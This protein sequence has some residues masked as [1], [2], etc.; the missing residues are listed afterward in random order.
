MLKIRALLFVHLTFLGKILL[1]HFIMIKIYLMNL[2][3]LNLKVE[4][5]QQLKVMMFSL[6]KYLEIIWYLQKVKKENHSIHAR[7]NNDVI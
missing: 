3:L 2:Y 5:F 4:I 1:K 7:I 6:E